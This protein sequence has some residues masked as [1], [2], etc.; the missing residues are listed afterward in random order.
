MIMLVLPLLNPMTADPSIAAARE[1]APHFPP[2]RSFA[3]S[4]P[5]RK[6]ANRCSKRTWTRTRVMLLLDPKSLASNIRVVL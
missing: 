2:H 6:K 1:L 4:I 5:H 3:L